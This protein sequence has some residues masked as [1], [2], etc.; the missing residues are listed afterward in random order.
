MVT[1]GYW[2]RTWKLLFRVYIYVYIYIGVALR[3][4]RANGKENA[5]YYLGYIL[6]TLGPKPD[7]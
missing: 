5:S 2:T 6:G 1:K 7:I 4:Y 3:V